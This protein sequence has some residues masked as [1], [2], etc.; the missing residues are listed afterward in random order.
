MPPS[1]ITD[2]QAI[3]IMLGLVAAIGRARPGVACAAATVGRALLRL[4]ARSK[5]WPRPSSP[6]PTDSE[7]SALWSQTGPKKIDYFD[8]R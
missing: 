5:R 8:H 2:D 4:A 1:I 6:A 7:S 3:A